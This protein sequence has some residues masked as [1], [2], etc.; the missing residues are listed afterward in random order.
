MRIPRPDIDAA[1][2]KDHQ[3]LPASRKERLFRGIILL[4]ASVLFSCIAW[5]AGAYDFANQNWT[6]L[7]ILGIV[8]AA[9][10]VSRFGAKWLVR[11]LPGS[12]PPQ[13]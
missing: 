9:A 12:P 8:A 7:C 10:I 13:S 1:I 5:L 2:L 6:Y 11:N 3:M 4:T